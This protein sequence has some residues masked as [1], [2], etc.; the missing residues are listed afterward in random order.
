MLVSF[1]IS[2]DCPQDLKDKLCEL[3]EEAQVNFV[4]QRKVHCKAKSGTITVLSIGLKPDRV[5]KIAKSGILHTGTKGYFKTDDG[6]GWWIPKDVDELLH[7]LK[8]LPAGANYRMVAGN[9]GMGVYAKDGP[10]TDFIDVR[11]LL[12][13]ILNKLDHCLRRTEYEV[14]L[15]KLTIFQGP[16]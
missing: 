15:C 1:V 6:S 13:K 16:S 9:T 10:Y 12:T 5:L 11:Y 7:V 4:P 3:K 8:G 2:K 14:I